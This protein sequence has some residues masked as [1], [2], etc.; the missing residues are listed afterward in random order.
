[1]SSALVLA[2]AIVAAVAALIAFLGLTS[3]RSGA[4]SLA[5]W[6][7]AWTAHL[8]SAALVLVGLE[9]ASVRPAG[10]ATSS[11]VAPLM[12]AGCSAFVGRASPPW[13][14]PT[15]AAYAG[16]RIL[17]HQLGASDLVFVLALGCEPVLAVL[18]ARIVYGDPHR[19]SRLPHDRM[20]VATMLLYGLAEAADAGL[21]L[22]GASS[23]SVWGAW[24]VLGMP[25]FSTQWALFI[26]RVDER[27][28]DARH[29]SLAHEQRLRI[30]AESN[31]AFI[32]ECDELGTITYASLNLEAATRGDARDIIGRNASEFF[33]RG[34][35]S[36]IKAALQERGRITE[37]DILA[38]PRAPIQATHSDGAS[39]HYEATRTTYRTAEGELRILTQARN[40][41]DRVLRERA[42]R[43]SEQRLR[44]AEEVGRIGSWE[45]TAATD[46]LL[47]S[48]HMY[49][50]HGMTPRPGPVDRRAAA[51]VVDHGDV[52]RMTKRA[53]EEIEGDVFP[54]FR[55]TIRRADTGETRILQTRGEVEFDANGEVARVTGASIDITELAQLEDALRRGRSH[56]DRFVDANIVGA[57]YTT[58]HGMIAEAN[59][60]FLRPIGYTREDLPLDWRTITPPEFFP[61][62]E[63][64]VRELLAS[65]TAQPYE[66]EFVTRD[67]ARVPMLIAV[68]RL[69]PDRSLVIALDLSERKRAEAWV[70][71]ER[72]RLEEIVDARTQELL[73][74]RHALLEAERLAAVG[75]LAAGVAHQ[76]NNPIGAILN[77]AEY[78]LLCRDDENADEIYR[79]AI[80]RNLEEARRCAQ[81]VKSMLQFSRDESADK[82]VEDLSGVV[83]RAHRAI[84]AYALDRD[85]EVE[86]S[87]PIDPIHARI[88]P[89]EI[90]QAIVNVLRNAI[91]SQDRGVHVRLQLTRRDKQAEIEIVDD[92]RGIPEASRDHLFDPFYTTRT[93]EGGTGLGLSVS[94]GILT[95]HGGE[96]RI[97]T[98]LTAEGGG[99]R[100]LL[101]LP[102][103]DPPADPAASTRP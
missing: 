96:I 50:L 62:D 59:D 41:T 1:M 70:A 12:V 22:V 43:D 61:R 77:S 23:W 6:M 2:T 18:G 69:D 10:V 72:N 64:A 31:D 14:I 15:A 51:R 74:S 65:G 82:W 56:L 49:R 83:R 29:L 89:I 28:T 19:T 87:T 85:A 3:L 8:S 79:H 67:G 98:P 42:V 45:Y 95:D 53:P 81:I 86:I 73:E 24:L 68:A 39:Q 7:F 103:E 93:K 52:V 44:R 66:K 60:A 25:L 101:S 40:V 5:L 13:L 16:A 63:A 38:A 78:A 57:L 97:D 76:I 90:E 48:D 80:Q 46:A 92:G 11:L 26:R 100:V 30:L 94:H 37:A 47:W 102:V 33:E 36:P 58:H 32:I 21:H 84:T 99:T 35:D 88:C 71:A 17:A 54:E 27:I 34:E 55:Y 20:L 4:R 75:T 91:E 9:L